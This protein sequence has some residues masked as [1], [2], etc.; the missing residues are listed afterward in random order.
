MFQIDELELDAV[1]RV[2]ER[3]KLFRYQMS[4]Q[5]ECDLFE[6]EFSKKLKTRHSLM[7]SSGTNA[8]IAA[9]R[10]CEIGPGDEVIVPAYT[11]VATASAVAQ[12]GA[13]V[14]VVNVDENLCID[15]KDLKKRI[16]PRTRCLIPVHM[17]GMASPIKSIMDIASEH[18]LTVI[19]DVAQ[20]LGGS[21]QGKALGTW[22]KLG[23]F[24]LNENKIISCGEGGLIVTDSQEHFEKAFAFHDG[25]AMFFPANHDRFLKNSD[26]LGGSMRVS[27]IS[28]AIMRVQIQRLD[29]LLRE[30]RTRK[31]IWV[32]Q[33]NGMSGITIPRGACEAGDCGT[34]LHLMFNLHERAMQAVQAL[35]QKQL[36]FY[37]VA[38]RPAHVFWK[39]APSL[40][41]G[42]TDSHSNSS[43]LQ[44]IDLL[45]RV[46][47]LD[48]NPRLD[49]EEV[50]N[51]AKVV[52]TILSQN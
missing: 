34:S 29:S 42:M 43:Y 32:D 38:A 15:L 17:D 23:C 3:K 9:L 28:G 40:R 21:F 24:S 8:L 49:L 25:A 12:V 10:A 26:A 13:Q 44:S 46:L 27:E 52:R 1:R 19:E 50:K 14:V 41:N 48:L 5:G 33:L 45:S 22:G 39:W 4:G 18:R 7:V 35:A 16:G 6:A 51:Q 30:L 2:F 31:K 37:P 36:A 20:A 11:F 47:K